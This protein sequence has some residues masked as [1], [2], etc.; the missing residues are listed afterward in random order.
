[1][2]GRRNPSTLQFMHKLAVTYRGAGQPAAARA[3]FLDRLAAAR[4]AL[5]AG[6]VPLAG[7]LTRAGA[8]LMTVAGH[9][10]RGAGPAGGRR[11]STRSIDP[12]GWRG[13]H[14]RSLL[15]AALLGQRK[16]ADAEPHLTAG[17][18]GLAAR[19]TAIPPRDRPRLGEAADR[20]I[21]LYTATNKP[22]EVKRWRAERAKYPAPAERGPLPRAVK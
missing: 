13:P 8:D 7:E 9:G 11:P 19:A 1:M 14:A 20:L 6:G 18:A 4:A 3:A 10:R 17:Y 12:D 16:Y 21:E 5:P 15:G 22:D 2:G